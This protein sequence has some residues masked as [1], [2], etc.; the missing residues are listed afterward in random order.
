MDV[1]VCVSKFLYNFYVYLHESKYILNSIRSSIF[2]NL[3]R[4]QMLESY[5][6][7]FEKETFEKKRLDKSVNHRSQFSD[8]IGNIARYRVGQYSFAKNMARSSANKNLYVI[9]YSNKKRI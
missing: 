3:C 2:L 5:G 7:N 6:N 4:R 8:V 1:Y 9:I